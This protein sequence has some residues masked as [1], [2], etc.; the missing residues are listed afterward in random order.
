VLDGIP[1]NVTQ[2]K[3]LEDTIDVVKIIYLVCAD[4]RK[5][6]ERLR[7]RA[8]KENRF[9]DANDK[10]IQNR[11]E[12]Y[13][14][15]TKPVLDYYPPDKIVRVDA[16]MNQLAVLSEIIKVLAPIKS[17][18]DHARDTQIRSGLTNESKVGATA[19][20]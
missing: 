11:L 3:L 12:V 7:R 17:A 1:R 19:A 4:M 14:R 16:T 10:V 2:A 20:G 5:M 9:D 6:I 8:L 15:D 18:I 13:E